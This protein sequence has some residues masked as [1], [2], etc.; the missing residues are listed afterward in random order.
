MA[1]T[2]ITTNVIA[3]DAITTAKIADDAVGNDQL[4]SGLTLGGNTAATL[5]TAAQPNITSLGTLSALTISGDLTV[6][7]STLKVDSSNNRV[8]IGTT[9]MASY[10]SKDL[11]VAPAADQGGITIAAAANTHTNYLLFSDGTSGDQAYR[12]QIAYQHRSDEDIMSIAST[13]ELDFRAGSSRG[14]KMTLLSGGNF[15]IGEA[16][17]TEKLHVGGAAKIDGNLYLATGSNT[18]YIVGG[19]VST[20][21]RNNANSASLVTILNDGKV[22]IGDS[23]P[24]ALLDVGGG[25][26]GNTSVATFAH[27]TDAYIEIE[28]MTTQNGAGIILTNAGSKKWTI[29]KDTSAHGL[30]IQDASTNANMTFLQ[31]GYV[32]IGTASPQRELHVQNSS[33]GATSTSNSVAVFEGNDNTEVSILGGSSS[34]LALNFG[35]SGDNN[36]GLLYFNTTSGSENMQL[37]SSKDITLR[38]TAGNAAAGD[39]IVKSYN[40]T[41][42]VFDGATNTLGIGTTTEADGTAM[43]SPLT[44]SGSNFGGNIF[45]AHRTGNSIHRQYMSTGGLSYIDIYGTS[46]TLKIRIAGNDHTNFTVAGITG[47]FFYASTNEYSGN[48]NNLKTTGFYRSEN[49][50]TNNPS[51]AY[52]SVMVYGNQGNVTAQIATL[53]SGPATYVRSFNTSWTSWVRIDD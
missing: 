32:G 40:T 4:A 34:V 36:E 39:V 25:Y 35:H 2:K 11:V 45:E 46:P 48:L 37:E 26:G 30:Y 14:I 13:G 16:T 1:N 50:N 8:G 31:G 19:T 24:Q 41:I 27:A 15:G 51:Y 38:V 22:G 3:D 52:Y 28:N 7:T 20:V 5:S 12:G 42:A 21:F 47:N 9:A 43:T 6:D 53:L 18:P 44:I 23:T 33:S 49:S 17:P 10:Y 29:Q